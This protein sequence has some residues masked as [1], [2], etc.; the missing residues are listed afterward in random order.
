MSGDFPVVPNWDEGRQAILNSRPVPPPRAQR[1]A[2]DTI[3]VRARVVWERDGEE[4]LDTVAVA[5]T[6]RLVL[7]R[8]SDSRAV[9]RG[10]WLVPTDVERISPPGTGQP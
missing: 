1:G 5:W 6:S 7:V 10:A 9:V 4:V 2:R 8:V 3:R